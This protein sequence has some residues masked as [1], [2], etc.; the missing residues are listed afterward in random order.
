MFF[1]ERGSYR[2]GNFDYRYGPSIML[3]GNGGIDAWFASPGDGKKEYDWITY[4]HS[5]DG[6]KTW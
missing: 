1:A 6:G 3:D 2:T 4:R 5:D